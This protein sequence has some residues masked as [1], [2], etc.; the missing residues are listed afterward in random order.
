[1][2]AAA[3]LDFKNVNSSELHRV[4]SSSF[5]CSVKCTKFGRKMHH[6]H[7]EMNT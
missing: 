6:G 1:M 4:I 3:I 2:A 7:A 5:Y